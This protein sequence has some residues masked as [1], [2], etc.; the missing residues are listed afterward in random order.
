MLKKTVSEKKTWNRK[1]IELTIENVKN[2]INCISIQKTQRKT[3]N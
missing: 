1:K 3:K 2:V